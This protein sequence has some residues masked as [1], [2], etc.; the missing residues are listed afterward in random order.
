MKV[1]ELKGLLGAL[2]ERERLGLLSLARQRSFDG[3][4]ILLRQGETASH[5]FVLTHGRVKVV[6]STPD[7]QPI[8]LAVRGPGDALGELAILDGSPRSASAIAFEPVR[9]LSVP[10]DAF[11]RYLTE[12]P[13]VM[14]RLLQVLSKLLRRADDV[15]VE[16]GTTVTE[17][18]VARRLLELAADHGEVDDDGS[19]RV[20]LRLSQEDLAGWVGAS[21]EGVNK[22]LAGLRDRGILETGRQRLTI[23]DVDGLKLHAV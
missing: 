8:L 9:A 21:R 19:V 5:L 13:L 18:R 23:L 12:H 1:P 20:T 10:T 6:A 4:D 17:Q 3:G 11:R 22:I 15:I 16:Q 2:S 7:G 14:M